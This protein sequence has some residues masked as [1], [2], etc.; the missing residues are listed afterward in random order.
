MAQQSTVFAS[1]PTES[2]VHDSGNAPSLGIRLAVGLKPVTPHNAA[3]KRTEPRVSDPSPMA[4]M[5]SAT[6]TAAPED[7]PPGTRPVLRSY[8]LR[9]VP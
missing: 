7:E 3:G 1:G 6:E 5:P 9:G 8:G 4:H 2:S